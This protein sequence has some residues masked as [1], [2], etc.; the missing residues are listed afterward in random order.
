MNVVQTRSEHLAQVS[1]LFDQY[2]VFYNSFSDY[3]AAQQFIGERFNNQDSI[4]LVACLDQAVVGFTQL[5]PSFSSVSMQHIW[6]LN[7]LFVE[8]FHRGQGIGK[9]LLNAARAYAKETGAIRIILAT[10]TSNK[11]AQML[12]EA[13]GYLKDD[14][15][16]HYAL[17]L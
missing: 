9:A 3:D 1:Q 12:Y 14:E 10:Q 17:T 5:Y 4:I 2:R 16:C 7:D 8:E 6:I 11:S 13:S 15:F